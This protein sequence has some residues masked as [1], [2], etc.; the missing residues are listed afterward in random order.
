MEIAEEIVGAVAVTLNRFG[1]Q[2]GGEDLDLGCKKL[3]ESWR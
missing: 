3:V 2:G 1:P